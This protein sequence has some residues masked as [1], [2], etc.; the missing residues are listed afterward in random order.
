MRKVLLG[1]SGVEVSRLCFGTLTVGPLQANMSPQAG[2]EI[3][4][5]AIERGVNFCDAAQLY[6]TYPHIRRAMELTGERGLVVASK[7]YA[8]TRKQAME[9]VEQ[10]RR[11]LDRD[12]ID[13]FLLHEQESIHTLNGH[14]E[15]LEYLLECKSKGIIRAVG[16]SMHRVAAVYGAIEKRLDIIHPLLNISGLGIADGTREDMEKAVAKAHRAGTGVYGMKALGGGNLF[17]RAEECL[18]YVL[19]LDCVDALAVGMQSVSE[20]AANVRFFE[21]GAFRP[22]E[23]AALQSRTRRL[24]IDDWCEGCGKCAKACGQNALRVQDGKA[25]C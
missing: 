2:G 24:H 20:V 10:A 9:A 23:K 3:I 12:Y 17:R 7:T 8:Y 22:E 4:A 11:E 19:G 21:A 1:A 25:R 6:G 5:A 16:A 15:A 13:I 18:S 14:A